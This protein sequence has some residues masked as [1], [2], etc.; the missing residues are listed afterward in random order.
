VAGR[1]PRGIAQEDVLKWVCHWLRQCFTGQLA[2]H[3]QSQWHTKPSILVFQN[4]LSEKSDLPSQSRYN[5]R[6]T[7]LLPEEHGLPAD[8]KTAL[9]KVNSI[10]IRE[11]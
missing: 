1:A 8:L 3:W 6:L 5:K 7:G 11:K 9:K 10:A 2:G 4:T